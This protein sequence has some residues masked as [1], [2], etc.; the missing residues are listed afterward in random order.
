[1]GFDTPAL[2]TH[3]NPSSNRQNTAAVDKQL[4]IAHN[5]DLG[6]VQGSTCQPCTHT[7]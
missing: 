5:Q 4:G 3:T 6:G 7:H 2:H 1:L